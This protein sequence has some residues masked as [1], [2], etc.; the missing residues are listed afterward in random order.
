MPLGRYVT[1]IMEKDGFNTSIS[2]KLSALL[3][4]C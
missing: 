1:D 2:R 3:A 4:F